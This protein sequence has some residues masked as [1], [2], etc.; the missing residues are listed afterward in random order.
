MNRRK[1]L[2]LG[3]LLFA[4]VVF[5]WG[6]RQCLAA[7]SSRVSEQVPQSHDTDAIIQR[8]INRITPQ[9]RAEAA[10]RAKAEREAQDP[11]LVPKAA[12]A[13]AAA[14]QTTAARMAALRN[15]KGPDAATRLRV[16]NEA[17]AREA[18]ARKEAVDAA[19]N[20]TQGG[21]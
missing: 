14:A 15:A 19:A 17:G 12:A 20:S 5:F 4:T 13:K 16:A 3:T 9:Q 2:F 21:I 6:G 11:T 8:K 1:P 7:Q 10:A 18:K